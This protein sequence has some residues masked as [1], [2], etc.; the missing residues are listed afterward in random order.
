V[1]PIGRCAC[2]IARRQSVVYREMSGRDIA[3][4]T[5]GT[6]HGG[7]KENIIP[8]S[9]VFELNIRTF[10]EDVREVVLDRVRRIILAEALASGAPEPLIEDMYRFPRCYNDPDEAEAFIASAASEL[11]DE[12]VHVE[13]PVTGSKDFGASDHYFYVLYVYFFPV[14]YHPVE[15][16][17]VD[18]QAGNLSPFFVSDDI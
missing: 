11:G 7:R 18:P 17:G 10:N 4:V 14:G 15:V 5:V 1:G 12:H 3:V 6:F 2:M 13:C 9:A 16:G 8:D